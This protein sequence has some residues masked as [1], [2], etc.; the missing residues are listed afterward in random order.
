MS[1][2]EKAYYEADSFWAGAALRDPGNIARMRMT[3]DMVPADVRTLLD[4]GCGNGIFGEVLSAQ[5]PAIKFV[6]VDRSAAAIKHAKVTCQLGSI[7]HLPFADGE[8]DCV[9]C[10]QVLE[11]LPVGVYCRALFELVRVSRKYVIVG[12][13]YREELSR[14]V[15]TCPECRTCFNINLHLRSY[16]D[17][18]IR[19]LLDGS[20]A[21]LIATAYPSQKSRPILLNDALAY[22]RRDPEPGFLS[23]ICPVCGYS[24]GDRTPLSVELNA[25]AARQTPQV[26]VWRNALM[27]GVLRVWPHETVRG[28]WVIAVYQLPSSGAT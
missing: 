25:P 4:A 13:P 17:D 26:G 5:R 15:T 3:A 8:F 6:G 11:H 10:L 2:F 24:E 28:Y 19:Q 23:P 22:F 12:L 7:D 1:D 18:K 14:D 20:G 21:R 9:T 27:R 16:D